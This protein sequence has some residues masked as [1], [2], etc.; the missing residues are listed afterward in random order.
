MH[1]GIK[2]K[3]I[4][5]ISKKLT[6]EDQKIKKKHQISAMTYFALWGDSLGFERIKYQIYGIKNIFSYWFKIFKDVAAIAFLKNYKIIK[7]QSFNSKN[8]KRLI[9]SRS[10]IEDFDKKGN[11]K[12]RY[13]LINSNIEKKT[14]FILINSG[15]K[16]P[17]KIGKNIIIIHQ[18]GR[19][20]NLIFLIKYLFKKLVSSSFSLNKFMKT[21][22]S[23]NIIGELIID[24][25]D[26]E[27]NFKTIK[28]IL[29]PYEGQPYEHLIFEE[30]RKNNKKLLIGGYDHS[31]PHSI[32]THLIYRSFSPD[33][34]YV[35][36]SSQVK[37]STT[38][39]NWP[40]KRIKLVPSLRY[41]K[42]LKLDFQNKVFLPYNIPDLKVV[43]EEFKKIISN[44]QNLNFESLKIRNHPM[45]KNSKKHLIL[46]QKL[47]K[48]INENKNNKKSKK[49]ASIF[50]GATTGVIVAL[51]K[52]INVIHICFDSIFDSYSQHLWPNLIVNQISRNSFTYRLK[53]YN[54]FLKFN[55]NQNCYKKY[56]EI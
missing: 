31:A 42:K 51:E 9:I 39:L 4:I 40:K 10:I 41:P 36:G 56:Y 7:N 8:F 27:I 15:K 45:M 30:A 35:N 49:Y 29:V 37:F 12:D 26:K 23:S 16:I 24:F 5:D 20:I 13:F 44:H 38:F 18:E 28:S 52:K 11:Y 17:K 54:T 19:A 46:K 21:T 6:N 47:E 43:V 33:I 32:P 34:M 53:K 1:I 2:Q 14:L 55:T 3:A 25:F 48:I 50:I 22:S